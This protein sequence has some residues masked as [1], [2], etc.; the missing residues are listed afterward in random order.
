[1][2]GV[3]YGPDIS[4][5]AAKLMNT[6]LDLQDKAAGARTGKL[7]KRNAL[8]L[9]G[10]S[11][12]AKKLFGLTDRDI[13]SRRFKDMGLLAQYSRDG[14]LLNKSNRVARR[15][16]KYAGAKRAKYARDWRTKKIMKQKAGKEHLARGYSSRN[17]P[18]YRT[19][20]PSGAPEA[21]PGWGG[22]TYLG[23][24]APRKFREARARTMQRASRKK[25]NY[26]NKKTGISGSIKDEADLDRLSTASQLT[27]R[28][29]RL[30]TSRSGSLRKGGAPRPIAGRAADAKRKRQQMNATKGLTARASRTPAKAKR[31]RGAAR[32]KRRS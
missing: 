2:P 25:F 13:R 16:N 8:K 22:A 30:G 24:T 15:G 10:A 29:P 11:D 18:N 17:K 21:L 20:S 12:L 27:A 23:R 3:R 9:K 28:R 31:A 14:R 1:M 26:G 32:P 6:I 4:D 7:S 5:D 19:Y